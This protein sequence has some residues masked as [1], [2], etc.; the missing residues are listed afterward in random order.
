MYK[1]ISGL[2]NEE[3]AAI[4]YYKGRGC[5][6]QMNLL[7]NLEL[8]VPTQHQKNKQKGTVITMNGMP[9]PSTNKSSAEKHE[10]LFPFS[11]KD[12]EEFRAYIFHDVKHKDFVPINL[13]ASVRELYPFIKDSYSSRLK[14][15]G[16]LDKI[17]ENENCPVLESTSSN[18]II[19]Y[20]RVMPSNSGM[21]C[22]AA[23]K[24]LDKL[25][26][27]STYK[28]NYFANAQPNEP[29]IE[30][31]LSLSGGAGN[32]NADT[33]NDSS[34][35]Y[36]FVMKMSGTDCKIPY[37]SLPEYILPR[38][39]EVKID[40]IETKKLIEPNTPLTTANKASTATLQD[41]DLMKLDKLLSITPPPENKNKSKS[42]SSATSK[43]QV[44]TCN[45]IYCS[46]MDWKSPQDAIIFDTI[47]KN[48]EIVLDMS[49]LATWSA[50]KK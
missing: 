47:S 41:K 1:F 45:Y 20:H 7:M 23:T 24:K 3:T 14:L 43:A 21:A 2:T 32:E 19:L 30:S 37:L 26:A 27:G 6:W 8:P 11:K 40:K 31:L 29:S 22:I 46:I 28:F 50:A 35:I 12:E 33:K 18:P 4:R 5:H 49:A 9:M 36:V 38:N 39:L 15:L 42:S 17:F 10:L 25:K 16:Y 34:R 13:A 44:R 48:A